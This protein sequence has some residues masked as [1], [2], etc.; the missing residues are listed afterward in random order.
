MSVHLVWSYLA[1]LRSC[2]HILGRSGIVLPPCL[3]VLLEWQRRG[4]GILKV[5]LWACRNELS[6][7]NMCLEI[8][9]ESVR[10]SLQIAATGVCNCVVLAMSRVG[11]S[12]CSLLVVRKLDQ[13]VLRHTLEL[14]WLGLKRVT[15]LRLWKVKSRDRSLTINSDVRRVCGLGLLC[16]RAWH[17]CLISRRVNWPSNQTMAGHLVQQL[18]QGVQIGML[19]LTLIVGVHS[20]ARH[21]SALRLRGHHSCRAGTLL[22]SSIA[23][24]LWLW[25]LVCQH[26]FGC[27]CSHSLGLSLDRWRC[28]SDCCEHRV[29]IVGSNCHRLLLGAYHVPKHAL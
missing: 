22:L 23:V 28:R 17:S 16:R 1:P 20:G 4:W 3:A 27:C 2:N 25:R 29:R 18:R 11:V 12:C 21:T 5:R 15:L 10:P 7:V 8:S 14:W 9:T 26:W 19:L 6:R 13:L 24:V